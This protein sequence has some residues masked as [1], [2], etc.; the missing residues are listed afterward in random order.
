MYL[1]K[2]LTLLTKV[3]V[4]LT[5]RPKLPLV[6]K[7]NLSALKVPSGL[8]VELLSTTAFVLLQLLSDRFS[9]LII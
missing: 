8:I 2:K 5:I 7:V 6:L 3:K 9:E 4:E 1:I